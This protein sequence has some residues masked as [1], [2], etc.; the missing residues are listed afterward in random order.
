M[1]LLFGISQLSTSSVNEALRLKSTVVKLRTML[2]NVCRSSR[3]WG[4]DV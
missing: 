1:Q 2:V 4:Q 3:P